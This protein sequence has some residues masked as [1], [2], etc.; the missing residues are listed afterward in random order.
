MCEL[1]DLFSRLWGGNWFMVDL[2]SSYGYY[3]FAFIID[4]LE[5][6][7]F[8]VFRQLLWCMCSKNRM[9]FSSPHLWVVPR[10]S[11]RAIDSVTRQQALGVGSP[12]PEDE[13]VVERHKRSWW[14]VWWGPELEG[15]YLLWRKVRAAV[16]QLQAPRQCYWV[17]TMLIQ[18]RWYPE[19]YL[20]Y[21]R[22]NAT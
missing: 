17:H 10:Q 15:T 14:V 13:G 2:Q 16:L 9:R 20:P 5:T 22:T 7:M 12:F 11:N 21:P 4:G 6:E 19:G 18:Q 8:M 1:I 3:Y